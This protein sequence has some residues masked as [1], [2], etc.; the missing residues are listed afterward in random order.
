MLDQKSI[1]NSFNNS[2]KRRNW[3]GKDDIP[4]WSCTISFMSKKSK[5]HAFYMIIK[6]Q[7]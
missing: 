3:C 2:Y 7:V 4:T 1:S 5:V 6:T